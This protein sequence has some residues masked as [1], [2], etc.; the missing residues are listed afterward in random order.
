MAEPAEDKLT[1]EMKSHF[2]ALKVE[3]MK[4]VPD[5][6]TIEVINTKLDAYEAAN[7]EL[8]AQLEGHKQ[9]ELKLVEQL[10]MLEGEIARKVNTNPDIDYKQLPEYK[11]LEEMVIKGVIEDP[12]VKQLLRT[13]SDPAGGFLTTTEMD[14]QITKKITEISPVRAVARV[15]TTSEKSLMIPV[16]NVILQASYEGETATSDDDTST[17]QAETLTP[18]RLAVTVPITW[19]MLQDSAFDMEAEIFGDAQE[20]FAQKEGNKF[21][22]GTGVKE[23]AGFIDNADVQ[24]AA[25]DGSGSST[26]TADDLLLLT[27]DL[28]TGY[29]PNY[30]LNRRELAFIRT[31]K[32]SDG[33]F[34]WQPGLNGV[35]AS[36]LNGFNYIIAN[37]MPDKATDAFPIAFADF[38]R[39]YTIIDRTGTRIIRDEVTRKKEAIVEFEIMRWNTGQV[40]LVE[41]IKLLKTI[42]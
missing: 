8:V 10:E 30:M 11:A 7:Q 18:F 6:K 3:L 24:A 5:L 38:F 21:I 23:P 34:L 16:R 25:R 39:G 41:A 33:H 1:I 27:G 22:L 29:N 13:D 15:R 14:N 4:E 31:L 37:D 32:G 35:V 9:A 2:E 26:Y 42:A 12:E 19:D 40:I 36:T 28:K 20:S 17:Y